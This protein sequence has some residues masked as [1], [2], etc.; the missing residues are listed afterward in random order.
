[1]QNQQQNKGGGDDGLMIAGG[2]LIMLTVLWLGFRDYVVYGVCYLLYWLY[3][4][5]P[6][7]ITPGNAGERRAMLQSAAHYNH[8]V[9][10]WDFIGVVNETASVL[11]P[12]FIL[13]IGL[14]VW[15]ISRNPYYRLTRKLTIRNLPWVM[16]KNYPGIAHILARFGHF[17]QLLLNEDPEEARSARSP[18]EFSEQHDLIDTARRRLRKKAA[19]KVFLAQVNLVPDGA[20][21]SLAP[22]EKALAASFVHLRFMGDRPTAKAILDDLNRS[23][24]RTK[25]GFPDYS[26][27]DK[28]WSTASACEDFRTF[29]AGRRSSRT[30]LHALFDDDLQLP[31][32]HFRW[33]KGVDRT[34]WY[35]LSSVGRGKY[36]IEGAGVIAWSQCET[37]RRTLSE[38]RAAL[39]P[40]TVRA[41]VLGLE[42]DLIHFR[43]VDRREPAIPAAELP[44]DV[45]PPFAFESEEDTDGPTGVPPAHA[46]E[47]DRPRLTDDE[48]EPARPSSAPRIDHLEL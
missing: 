8:Q 45:I 46:A 16:V 48:S 7:V 29:A 41:A 21:L 13:I 6:D 27:A 15:L 34:L 14:F 35:A 5:L 39:F 23:C 37:Y 32:A 4:V 2:V 33:L 12:L 19:H 3:T 22:W 43:L 1:M 47:P 17:D 10:L 25:D 28:F 38:D 26:L 9:S 11:F 36:F 20:A 44:E 42:L 18:M 24:L 31:S 30:L 40:A